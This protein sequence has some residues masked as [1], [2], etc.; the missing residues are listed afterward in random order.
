MKTVVICGSSRFKSEMRGFG[1]KLKEYGAVVLEPHL[2]S[3]SHTEWENL[4]Q[5]QKK[6]ITLGLTHDHFYKIH[7]SDVVFVYNKEGYVGNSLT[8]EIG[9]SVAKGKP[10]YALA[11]D[12]ELARNVLFREII[13]SP[14]ELIK[15]L[16]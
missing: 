3:P 14:E 4:S 10:I 15:R 7:I 1:E 9:Y 6:F 12:K 8:L 16:E 5:D 2:Y 11:E 13:S